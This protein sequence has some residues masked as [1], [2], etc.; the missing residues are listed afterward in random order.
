MNCKPGDLAVIVRSWAGNE[1][2]IV[3]CVRF[4]GRIEYL[5]GTIADS[6]EIDPPQIGQLGNPSNKIADF[7]LHPIR[8]NEGDD[9]TLMWAGK[10]EGVTA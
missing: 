1:G 6:W 9:E 2:K 7:Q 4:I 3:R 8:P 10:P 5:N